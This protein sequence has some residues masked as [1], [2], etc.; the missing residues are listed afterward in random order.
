M[1]VRHLQAGDH[2]SVHRG[3]Y[4]HHGIFCG[5]DTVIHY[6][7][8]LKTKRSAEVCATTLSAF[9]EGAQVHIVLH[10]SSDPPHIVIRRAKSRLGERCYDL[11]SNNCEH[12]A[13]SCKT[14]TGQSRQ[15]KA[16]QKVALASAGHGM[17]VG[18]RAIAGA[19][20]PA[21]SGIGM[22]TALP[23]LSALGLP[24]LLVPSLPA[25]SPAA[26]SLAPATCGLSLV[27]VGLLGLLGLFSLAVAS[28]QRENTEP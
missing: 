1:E 10:P 16:V 23:S 12:F 6:R 3:P 5:D 20:G 14:G 27:V 25:L 8:T 4:T 9:A 2:I 19:G 21:V 7:S 15:V 26:V 24:A 13:T 28:D 18:V 17:F 11:F 22:G